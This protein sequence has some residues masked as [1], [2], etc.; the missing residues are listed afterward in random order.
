MT[1]AELKRIIAEAEA[2][3][4]LKDDSKVLMSGERGYWK[5]TEATIGIDLDNRDCL[6]IQTSREESLTSMFRK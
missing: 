1:L 4:E 5:E 2:A 6:L 3:G